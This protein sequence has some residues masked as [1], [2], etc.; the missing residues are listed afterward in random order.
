MPEL[1]YELNRDGIL[2]KG[3][4]IG[5]SIAGITKKCVRHGVSHPIRIRYE[6]IIPYYRYNEEEHFPLRIKSSI[7]AY[8]DGM[9]PMEKARFYEAIL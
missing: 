6:G 9:S 3:S 4:A 1:E 2:K 5:G 8:T 7:L